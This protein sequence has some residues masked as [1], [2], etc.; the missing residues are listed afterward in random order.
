MSTASE[1]QRRSTANRKI[2]GESRLSIWLSRNGTT[3]LAVLEAKEPDLPR[4]D[5]VERA[6][7]E[8]AFGSKKEKH[9]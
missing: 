1:R 6:I 5:I 3:A 8:M 9:P 2:R 4:K 7:I